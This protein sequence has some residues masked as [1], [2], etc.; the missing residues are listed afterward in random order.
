MILNNKYEVLAM[1]P[2]FESDFRK[3]VS[4]EGMDYYCVFL[5]EDDAKIALEEGL[6][7]KDGLIPILPE[8]DI[9]SGP[10]DF[11]F[12]EKTVGSSSYESLVLY[13][14]LKNHVDERT[15]ILDKSDSVKDI[16]RVP[17]LTAFEDVCESEVIAPCYAI[18]RISTDSFEIIENENFSFGDYTYPY[19]NLLK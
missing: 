2:D 19:E 16:D 14:F 11:I 12:S 3:L 9:V 13:G 15:V 4:K 6:E 17:E 10:I 7:E 8:G 1:Y 18:C 5:S